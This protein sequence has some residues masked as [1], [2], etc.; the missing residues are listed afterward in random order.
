MDC[1]CHICGLKFKTLPVWLKMNTCGD[2]MDETIRKEGR[3]EALE[4]AGYKLKKGW[5]ERDE[6]C[7]LCF[8]KSKQRMLN[9]FG[10]KKGKG[11]VKTK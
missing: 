3:K 5:W 9:Y 11:K 6:N 7:P 4:R 2:C 8:C 1:Q 10:E